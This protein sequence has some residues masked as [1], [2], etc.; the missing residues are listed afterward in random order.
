MLHHVIRKALRDERHLGTVRAVYDILPYPVVLRD[1]PGS[2]IEFY[3]DLLRSKYMAEYLISFGALAGIPELH[4]LVGLGHEHE[5]EYFIHHMDA[6][7]DQCIL[8][9]SSV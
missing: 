8:E 5:I 9:L 7:P 2:I 3:N 6:A 4:A 1:D